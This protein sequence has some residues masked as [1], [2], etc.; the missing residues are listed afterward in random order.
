MIRFHWNKVSFYTYVQ[1]EIKV[2]SVEIFIIDNTLVLPASDKRRKGQEKINNILIEKFQYA[3]E[4]TMYKGGQSLIKLNISDTFGLHKCD[5]SF[6]LSQ[7]HSLSI[8]DEIVPYSLSKQ[9]LEKD[10]NL[11]QEFNNK[12]KDQ[13]KETI[14]SDEKFLYAVCV[15]VTIHLEKEEDVLV[16]FDKMTAHIKKFQANQTDVLI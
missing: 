14:L 12:I 9:E 4:S 11:I 3:I 5:V 16:F 8:S 2:E 15:N 13:L 6:P 10:K 1:I 7:E